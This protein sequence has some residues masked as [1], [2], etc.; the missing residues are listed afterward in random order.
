MQEKELNDFS[1]IALHVEALIF[2][3][4]KP[5]SSPEI[6]ELINNAFAFLEQSFSEEQIE[7]IITMVEAKYASPEA[8]FTIKETSGGWQFLTKPAYHKTIAQLNGEK[9]LKRLSTAAMETLAI[10]AY[11]QPVTKGEI[12]NIRGVN[13]DYSIQKLLEKELII[14]SGRNED[15]PGKPLLYATSR[16]FMDYFGMNS[17]ADLP[18]IK[19]VLAEQTVEPTIVNEERASDELLV[20]NNEGALIAASDNVGKDENLND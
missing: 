18:G 4:D 2:A 16:H 19:E 15:A 5:L 14:I 9:F 20:V 1:N 10:I 11:K 7:D 3:S 6:T 13:S 12:E 8:A 17:V